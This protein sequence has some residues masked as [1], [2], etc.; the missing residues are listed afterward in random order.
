[1]QNFVGPFFIWGFGMGASSHDAHA[2]FCILHRRVIIND[3][4]FRDMV[5][6][7]LFFFMSSALLPG[8][9]VPILAPRSLFGDF[10]SDP[11]GFISGSASSGVLLTV[12]RITDSRPPGHGVVPPSDAP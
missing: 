9:L 5:Q 1:M 4:Y 8:N 10:G 12:S 3:T 2:Q 11:L 6:P 7:S